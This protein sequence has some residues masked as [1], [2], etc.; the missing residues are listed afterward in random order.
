M[1]FYIKNKHLSVSVDSFHQ[2]PLEKLKQ[3]WI[4]EHSNVSIFVISGDFLSTNGGKWYAIYGWAADETVTS[5]KSNTDEWVTDNFE[6]KAKL[7]DLIFLVEWEGS[8]ISKKI[9]KVCCL[10]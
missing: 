1:S 6:N 2:D 3:K 8:I 4:T 7:F 9:N 10:K 5:V